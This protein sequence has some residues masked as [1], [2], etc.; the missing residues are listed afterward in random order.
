[1]RT[2]LAL[3]VLTAVYLLVLAST[4]PADA[5]TGLLVAGGA[6]AVARRA[7]GNP[8]TGT[9]RSPLALVPFLGAVLM[10]VTKGTWDVAL[11]VVG[12]RRLRGPGVV[13]I[14]IGDRTELGTVVS[15]VASTLSPGEVLIDIDADRGVYL[16]HALD[17]S[18][19]DDV[20]AHHLQGYER[21]QKRALP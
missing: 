13:E 7:P 3:A 12:L 2:L 10:E 11:V 19:P 21:W 15:A 17:A 20:R 14:P 9:L 4:E 1:M 6:L 16:I 5:V 8:R 18:D